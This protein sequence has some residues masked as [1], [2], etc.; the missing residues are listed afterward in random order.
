[1]PDDGFGRNGAEEV[2]RRF[3]SGEKKKAAGRNAVTL[4]HAV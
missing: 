2:P 3:V 1:M 4:F